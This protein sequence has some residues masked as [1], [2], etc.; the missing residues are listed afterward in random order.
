MKKNHVLS[1][2]ILISLVLSLVFSMQPAKAQDTSP[3]GQGDFVPGEVVVAF[4]SGKTI[5]Q[6]ASA[7]AELAQ[8]NHMKAVKVGAGGV[9]LLRGDSK[10]DVVQLAKALSESADV[11]YAEPNFIYR[12]PDETT[13]VTSNNLQQNFVIREKTRAD[14]AE[15]T[16]EAVP[17]EFLKS[18]KTIKSG[19][20]QATY[21]NDLYLWWNSG[22]DVVDADIVSSNTTASAGVCVL[23]TGVDYAHPDLS[24]KVTKGY[25]FVNA[26]ADPM[27]DY[28]HGTHVAGIIMAKSK[29]AIGI[30]GASTATVV[31]VKV[32]GSQGWGTS[33]DIAQGINF[34]ANRVDVKVLNMSLGGGYSDAVYDAVDYAVNVKGK[35]LVVSA[36]NDNTDDPTYAYPGYLAS[37]PEF[38][39]KVLAVAASGAY[40][41]VGEGYYYTDY[42]C[43]A[44]YSNY[45]DWVSVVA[46]GTDIYSTT[47]YDKPFYMNYFY[48]AYPR[49]EYLSGTSM[50][51][52]FVAAAAARRWGYKPLETNE[53][54]GDAVVNSGWTVYADDIC[55][56]STMS[57]VRQV[58]I[59]NLMDRFA[60]EASVADASTGFGLDGAQ[61][62]AYKGTTLLGSAVITPSIMSSNLQVVSG[63]LKE[64]DV[65][66][67]FTAYTTIINLPEPANG[68]F[69]FDENN[70]Y[71]YKAY[72]AN[73][74]A[75]SQPIF[76]HAQWWYSTASLYLNDRAGIP[77]KST[78]VD[79][80]LGFT[81]NYTYDYDSTTSFD[82]DV[83]V[84][85][86]EMPN[87]LDAGQPAPFIVGP[88]G[89]AW[90]FLEDDTSGSLNVFP[91][92]RY[93]RDGGGMDYVPIE[94]ITI[95]SR[96]AHA[97]LATNAALLYYPG[98]YVV[99]VS[100]WGQTFDHDSDTLTPEIPVMGSYAVPYIY[101][102]KDG[103]IK[104]F[105]EM[106]WMNA[107]DVCN[108][109]WWK[110]ATI[111]SGI[112]GT[113]TYT[114]NYDCSNTYDIFP[115]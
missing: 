72:K 97:P 75:S 16:K 70:G 54:V 14:G 108:T 30:A 26:D 84:W 103:V 82:L 95:S 91:F 102:W 8:K 48:S 89:Y 114:P 46:P 63:L 10:A 64:T 38:Y 12:L 85:L 96:K 19:K 83:N 36:G 68:D 18:L 87:P 110:A 6:Y 57:G 27:D 69:F 43:R 58:N 99:G 80:V 79:V 9:A 44:E 112:S 11:L 52:P 88:E 23:D 13:S 25:D 29:N 59:A 100:D 74:T 65:F 4:K 81:E 90:S 35:L 51:A 24:G 92:A 104:L 86:P 45:G 21:P 49:Y 40:V 28:G 94:N 105:H 115:Y 2:F 71:V 111:T 78:N 62:Q 37:Y 73:Y 107:N 34:C 113:I 56:P 66:K 42:S 39:N 50:A 33:Y 7:T 31:A 77:P 101:I 109:H 17:I 41:D 1:I 55:W 32:L 93:K 20:V 53:Q 76:Q 5:S 47:P 106:P 22:W 60:V 61:V 67:Y 15:V 3:S 98:S